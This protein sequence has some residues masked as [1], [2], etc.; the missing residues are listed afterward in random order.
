MATKQV[1]SLVTG[2][3]A[4]VAL[5]VWSAGAHADL[6]KGVQKAMKGSLVVTESAFA[7]PEGPDPAVIKAL[8]KASAK[9]IKGSDGGEAGTVWSFNFIAFMKKAPGRDA[10]SLDFYT[11]D[12]EKLY[13]ANKRMTGIDPKLALLESQVDITEDDGVKK[14]GRYLVKLSVSNGN[15]DTVLAET[16]LTLK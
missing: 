14:G 12:K 8:K 11:D 15:R 13:V 5:V 10:I 16:K 6:S 3:A 4:A 1:R 9:S 2:I 7:I